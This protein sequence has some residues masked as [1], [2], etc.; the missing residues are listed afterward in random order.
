MIDVSSSLAIDWSSS[1]NSQLHL[2]VFHVVGAHSPYREL[3]EMIDSGQASLEAHDSD[4]KELAYISR[5][6]VDGV[7]RLLKSQF[8]PRL[9]VQHVG[10]Q[11]QFPT[12]TGY[13]QHQ[14]ET[15]LV[16]PHPGKDLLM[17]LPRMELVRTDQVQ[18]S[19]RY[20]P[21]AASPC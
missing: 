11:D 16:H 21:L 10:M 14:V 15:S 19:R 5:V 12:K 20:M 9:R 2:L 4:R 7:P 1:H 17:D 6:R 8:C 3:G 13:E 18:E